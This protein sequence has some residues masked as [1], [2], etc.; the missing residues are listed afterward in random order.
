MPWLKFYVSDWRGDSRVRSLPREVRG[1][2]VDL[3]CHL[4][5]MPRRGYLSFDGATPMTPEQVARLLGIPVKDAEESIRTLLKVGLL[6]RD[7]SGLLYNN[8]MVED[9]KLLD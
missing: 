3:L 9:E 5:E 4:H 1:D 6:K 2:W 8:R 7:D